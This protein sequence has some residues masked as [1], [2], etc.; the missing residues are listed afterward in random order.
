MYFDEGSMKSPFSSLYSG[1]G[2]FPSIFPISTEGPSGSSVTTTKGSSGS[3]VTNTTQ[4][5]SKT[6]SNMLEALSAVNK[7]YSE[8]MKG[9][10][11]GVPFPGSEDVKLRFNA[12][13]KPYTTVDIT[14]KDKNGQ[15]FKSEGI[16]DRIEDQK[17][18][19]GWKGPHSWEAGSE[20]EK[21][22]RGAIERA[23]AFDVPR[24][25]QEQADRNSKLSNM[26]INPQT[27]ENTD[28]FYSK[29]NPLPSSDIQQYL[30]G[31]SPA[32][33]GMNVNPAKTIKEKGTQMAAAA[34]AAGKEFKY[35][36]DKYGSGFGGQAGQL[37][38]FP[39]AYNKAVQ[40]ALTGTVWDASSSAMR[41]S[42]K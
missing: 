22:M 30:E 19:V 5:A 39:M 41:R 17:V 2:T 25:K 10:Y 23:A 31:K 37:P 7:F 36:Q 20:D 13:G 11:K 42:K 9:M 3:S 6:S 38:L 21:A 27:M 12:Y 15:P 28:G 8:G 40:T 24:I 16:P 35:A 4:D 34:G 26:G 14:P 1:M 33:Q 18:R 32:I 29:L